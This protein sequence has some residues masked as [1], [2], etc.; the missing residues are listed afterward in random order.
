MQNETSDDR[1]NVDERDSLEEGPGVQLAA[2]G[3]R[4]SSASDIEQPQAAYRELFLNN[5]EPKSNNQ[6]S[7]AEFRMESDSAKVDPL[8]AAGF[9]DSGLSQTPAGFRVSEDGTGWEEQ[10]TPDDPFVPLPYSP[11]STAD[12]VRQSGLAWSA[13]IAF[14]G[15][16][17]FTLFLGWIADLLLGISPWG[18]VGGIVFGSIIGFLQFFRITSRIFPGRDDG[19]EITPLM[20]RK[21]ED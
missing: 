10:V 14:F 5:T 3:E 20:S 1:I 4:T 16:V 19:P 7:D 18:L 8:S 21:D 2:I 17:A 6:R 9:P 11:A 13:G 12:N 15:S